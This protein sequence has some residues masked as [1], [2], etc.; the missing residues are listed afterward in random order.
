[1]PRQSDEFAADGEK[2]CADRCNFE[3]GKTPNG[4]SLITISLESTTTQ[5]NR[6]IISHGHALDMSDIDPVTHA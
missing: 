6:N 4:R 1:M 3:K 5:F 2:K